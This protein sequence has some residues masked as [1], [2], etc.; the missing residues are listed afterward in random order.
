MYGAVRDARPDPGRSDQKSGPV[1]Q[2]AG[3]DPRE[4]TQ[5]LAVAAAMRSATS[6]AAVG[7]VPASTT[8]TTSAGAP[9]RAMRFAVG[10]CG[11]LAHHLRGDVNGLRPAGV[12]GRCRIRP[13]AVTVARL[14]CIRARRAGATRSASVFRCSR[15]RLAKSLPA[16][17]AGT[18][19]RGGS[20]GGRL[21][22]RPPTSRGALSVGGCRTGR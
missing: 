1:P 21:A 16:A 8:A 18:S 13:V 17:A 5:I 2:N 11:T 7:D 12:G 10:R 4:E 14:G 15:T 9:R 22:Q 19:L 20:G 6:A 3:T